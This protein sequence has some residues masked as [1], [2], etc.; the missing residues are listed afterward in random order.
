VSAGTR[1]QGIWRVGRTGTAPARDALV[2]EEPLEIRVNG[3]P[4]TLTMRT[5]GND[6]E[7]VL[8]FLLAEGL[9][10]CRADVLRL[11]ALGP[12]RNGNIVDVE[13]ATP[14]EPSRLTRHVYTSAACGVC[15]AA[16]LDAICASFPPVRAPLRVT[17]GTLLA[18]PGR[19][20]AA[21]AD[22]ATSGGVH[23]AALFDADGALLA[24]RED[25]G[26]HNAL[27]KLA[28]WAL[29]EGRLPLARHVVLLSG[30]ASFEMVHKA[31]AAGVPVLAAV[32]APSSLAVELAR[33]GGITLVGFL[34]EQGM[35]VYSHPE[36]VVASSERHT[37]TTSSR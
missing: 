1:R 35:N 6:A 18:L 19:M 21:Q 20:H 36:R 12:Q 22:F 28:G 27:D 16:S 2:I 11:D 37:G 34:R 15:G 23:A 32:S 14:F 17:A 25:V 4:L 3:A 30:R 8:G 31:L 9:I 5:P 26:R 7:Q 33:R 10:R 13:L 24:L 29:G